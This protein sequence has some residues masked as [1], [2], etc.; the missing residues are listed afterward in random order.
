LR[1]NN[2]GEFTSKDFIQS[3]EN[4]G[5]KRQFAAPRTPQQNGV[6]E[7]KNITI[8]EATITMLNEA[9][10]P[11][12]FWRDEIYTTFHILNR[13]QLRPNHDKTPYELWF[14]RTSTVK[15]FIIFGSK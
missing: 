4:Y 9:M 10:L 7:R 15:H 1:S 2:G 3:F 13:A 11:E 5:I 14:G 8:Q 6:V 12:K